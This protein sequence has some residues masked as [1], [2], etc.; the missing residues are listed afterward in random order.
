MGAIGKDSNVSAIAVDKE[1]KKNRKI[2]KEQKKLLQDKD[3]HDL[4]RFISF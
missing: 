1:A 4:S 2:A 3:R